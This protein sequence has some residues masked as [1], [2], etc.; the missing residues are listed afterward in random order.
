MKDKT[1]KFIY[2]FFLWA[3]LLFNS[4]QVL[5]SE[6]CDYLSFIATNGVKKVE[7]NIIGD[8]VVQYLN[9]KGIQIDNYDVPKQEIYKKTKK[10]DQVV[11]SCIKSQEYIDMGA[12]NLLENCEDFQPYYECLKEIKWNKDSSHHLFDFLDSIQPHLGDSQKI[13]SFFK[14]VSPAANQEAS[15]CRNDLD[16]Q[17]SFIKKNFKAVPSVGT[18]NS[19]WDFELFKGICPSKE[20]SKSIECLKSIALSRKFHLKTFSLLLPDN[21]IKNI[22]Q[23]FPSA[24]K[25]KFKSCIE[26]FKVNKDSKNDE[27]MLANSEY[28]FLK[29]CMKKSQIKASQSDQ[30]Q[31]QQN[32]TLRQ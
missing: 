31:K 9:S 17:I 12:S 23:N 20:H 13:A 32:S 8:S 10:L 24:D 22:C 1:F 5:S 15:Q 25:G 30:G 3:P 14:L 18:L 4:S 2:L 29:S 26:E 21:D 16:S 28:N 7:D 6:L 27:F 19:D 11:N